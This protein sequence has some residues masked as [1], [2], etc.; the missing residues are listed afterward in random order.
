[1]ERKLKSGSR[2]RGIDGV[3]KA[4]GKILTRR[5]DILTLMKAPSR[6]ELYGKSKNS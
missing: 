2:S 1:M 3:S 5:N 4:G 6:K